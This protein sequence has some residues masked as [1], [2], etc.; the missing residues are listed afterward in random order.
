MKNILAP[1]KT[2]TT[3][4]DDLVPSSPP[5]ELNRQPKLDAIPQGKRDSPTIE[6]RPQSPVVDQHQEH[7]IETP[8]QSPRNDQQDRSQSSTPTKQ[9]LQQE[10]EKV[11]DHP[12]SPIQVQTDKQEEDDQSQPSAPI[13]EVRQVEDRP[14]SPTPEQQQQRKIEDQENVQNEETKK[15]D[16]LKGKPIL[17]IG[18]GPGSGKGTQCEKI[19]E[20]YGFTHLSAGDL[21]RAAAQDSS[22]EK[23]R[24]FNEAMSQGKLISTVIEQNK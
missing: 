14:Q 21:I 3:A 18:G 16:I 9:Q 5:P 11:D 13:E 7:K 4:N 12:Q 15:K 20:H 6:E 1:L 23:G 24:Y 19:I 17:F 22:T 2:V 8:T 10:D